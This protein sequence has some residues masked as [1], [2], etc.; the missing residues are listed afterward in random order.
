MSLSRTVPTSGPGSSHGPAEA[1]ARRP[2]PLAVLALAVL[3][4]AVLGMLPFLQLG[5]GNNIPRIALFMGRFHP[6]VLH[7]PIGMILLAILLEHAHI[8]GLR[9]W[10]PKVPP[11]TSTFL[12]FFA[13]ASA[14]VSTVLGWMLSFSGG[15]DPALLQR[16]FYA[17]LCTAIGA[18]LALLLKLVS[19]SRPSARFARYSYQLVLLAT[20]GCLAL[21]GH[22]GASITHGEDY[23]TEYAPD[24]IRHL[25]G[26]PIRV[27]PAD[28]PWKPLPD[29]IAFTDV[30]GPILNDR[31]V[32]CHSGEKAKGGLRLDRFDE[33]MKGGNGGA[34][35]VA[36]QPD[37]SLM[38][39]YIDLPEDDEKHMPP[40]GKTQLSDDERAILGWW[41][42]AGA[43]E[44]ETIGALTVPADILLAMERAV[45]EAV[46]QKQEA[47]E[48]LQAAQVA[49][50]MAP[51]RKSMPGALDLIVPGQPG[52]EYSAASAP[53]SV[54]DAQLRQLEP[55][56]ANH[57]AKG[58]AEAGKRKQ[59]GAGVVPRQR[60]TALHAGED[61]IRVGS[62]QRRALRAVAD[63]HI[64]R[65]RYTL[66]DG[67]KGLHGDSEI[68]FRRDTPDVQHHRRSGIHTPR[69]AQGL[70][71]IAG[72]E[73]L[74]IDR[75]AQ[76]AR[77]AD[78]H[79][80]Q[81]VGQR[82]GGHQRGRRA[83]M[84]ATQV[85]AYQ[86]REQAHA[87]NDRRSCRNACGNRCSAQCPWTWPCASPTSRAG[88]RW[89]HRRRRAAAASSAGARCAPPAV[90]NASLDNGAGRRRARSARRCRARPDAAAA[91][92]GGSGRRCGRARR[93]RRPGC[94]R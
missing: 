7:V 81:F 4:L 72:M 10:I 58:F 54:G 67:A 77:V 36:S 73:Q 66:L 37:K 6:V 46:R 92:A 79:G 76:Q 83:L 55:L 49:A 26:L 18:N 53:A 59:I 43:P 8:R 57:V 80:V 62:L 42:Q 84:K 75:A 94:A 20:G 28:L 60:I 17:G 51:L 74:R 9:R 40:K 89:R 16:H 30:V 91:G 14:T 56:G 87:R 93:V 32:G 61:E 29:R 41:V 35:V 24:P 85:A 90:R 78:A 45:P 2:I 11:G 31:C 34:A 33:V 88:L 63:P 23:L 19:D 65:L 71:A 1:H 3:S 12:M 22:W 82:L 25:L 48:R 70:I 86:W 47:A 5:D 15:Y 69:R 52:I 44:N 13:A 64:A 21:A 38:L 39:R 50:A 27:D 68:L